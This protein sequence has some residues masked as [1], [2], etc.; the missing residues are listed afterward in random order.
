[1]VSILE[2]VLNVSGRLEKSINLLKVLEKHL[3]SSIGLEKSLKF[4]TLSK[5]RTIR[6]V[7]GGGGEFSSCR[8]FFSL[9]FPVNEF[10]FCQDVVHEYFFFLE[11]TLN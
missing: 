7:M 3:I 9:M 1:M 4:T 10:F 2:K 6:K 5:G 11:V 8:N